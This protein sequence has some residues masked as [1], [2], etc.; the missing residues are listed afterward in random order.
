M[1]NSSLASK[2]LNTKFLG[3]L[4]LSGAFLASGAM[5][6]SG[7]T[8]AF[9]GNTANESSWDAGTVAL[10]NNHATALFDGADIIPGYAENR[11]I[12]VKSEATSATTL[13]MYADTLADAPSVLDSKLVVSI[14]EGTGGVNST[15]GCTDFVPSAEKFSGTLAE[16]KAHNSFTSGLTESAVAAGASKQFKIDVTL[17]N[18]VGNEVQ[19]AASSVKFAWENRS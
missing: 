2:V 15:A 5:V 13:K 17:P 12:T 11:C 8:A 10:T 19:G 7:S 1:S 4:A 3:A 14:T 6:M 18:T 16:F 9:S